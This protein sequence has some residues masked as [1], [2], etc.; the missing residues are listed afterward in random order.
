MFILLIS[1][2]SKSMK[3]CLTTLMPLQMHGKRVQQQKQYEDIIQKAVG[4]FN[5]YIILLCLCVPLCH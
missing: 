1:G 4:V 3:G 2:Q 5:Q